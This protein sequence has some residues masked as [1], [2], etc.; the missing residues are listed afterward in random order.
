VEYGF[1]GFE[2]EGLEVIVDEPMALMSIMRYFEKEGFTFD[3]DLRVRMQ[4]A[5]RTRPRCSDDGNS[6][7]VNA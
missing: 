3:N 4:V 5:K 2:S 6:A 1:S 7:M